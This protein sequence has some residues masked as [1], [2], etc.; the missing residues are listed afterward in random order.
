MAGHVKLGALGG[1][2]TFGAQAAARMTE[3][4][5]EFQ[6]ELTFFPT[7]EEAYD[8]VVAGV[9]DAMCAPEQLK[10]TGFHAGSQGKIAGPEAKSYVIAEVA[11]EFHANLLVKAGTAL[12]R[13]K[14]VQGNT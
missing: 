7:A 4:Y 14:K 5:A 3:L 10:A 1:A 6:H 8:A 2:V 11:H 12:D 13:I 9:V